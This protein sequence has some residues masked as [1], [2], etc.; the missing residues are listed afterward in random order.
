[1]LILATATSSK[2][3]AATMKGLRETGQMLVVGIGPEPIEV[4]GYHL[5]FGGRSVEG[6]LTGDPATGD[7]TLKFSV[8][9]GVAAMIE[10]MPREKAP[11][12]SRLHSQDHAETRLAC[13]HLGEHG[14]E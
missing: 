1:M 3:M 8:L 2:A 12:E 6:S 11:P 14:T 7:K 9:S 10:T 5:V 13:H 4:S